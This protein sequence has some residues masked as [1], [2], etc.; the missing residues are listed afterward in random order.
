MSNESRAEAS[1]L[2]TTHYLPTY[3]LCRS[4][5]L[6]FVVLL[7]TSLPFSARAD[8]SIADR[9]TA[10]DREYAQGLEELADWC[11]KQKL[12]DQAAATR[13]WIKPQLPL[14]L[15]LAAPDESFA[16]T[17]P[18][19][20]PAGEWAVRFRKLRQAQGKS[21][22]ELAVAAAEQREFTLA[23][24]LVHATLREDPGQEAARRLLG[25]KQHEG[26]WLTQYEFNKAK[27]N[28][29]W[30]PQFG[31]IGRKQVARYEAGERFYKGRWISA[32][33]DARLHAEIDR[34][35][36]I[37]TE[38][39][40]VRTNHS[41][42]EGVVLAARLEEFYDVWRQLFVR[43][44]FTDEQLARSFRD[45]TPLVHRSRLHQ[46]TFFRDR[47]EYRAALAG[48]SPSIG[49][50]TGYYLPSARTAYFFAGPER[51]DANLCH[52]ATHQLFYEPK[53]VPEAA[54]DANFWVVEG[55]ACLMESYRRGNRLA[56]LGGADALRLINARN[57]LLRDD[58]YVGLAELCGLGMKAL[59]ERDDLKAI[60]SE[61]AGMTYFLLFADEGCYRQ[62]LVDYLSAVYTNRDRPATLSQ[63]TGASYDQLDEQYQRFIRNLP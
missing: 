49:I 10:L 45:S 59:Q 52:E 13:D 61:A 32:A 58:F 36:E 29:V 54:N 40:Q 9:Q 27:G 14:T 38:H 56:L 23:Y 48:E 53:L 50:T 4:A 26:K 51:E 21:L 18:R 39:F 41:L 43:F 57:R 33:D 63:L 24:Q 34:G 22:Y 16:D 19:E 6:L 5:R 2:L 3:S 12:L 60:Y 37:A 28:Q 35:W 30:H 25:Y 62:A 15:V 20:G 31:W 46:V 17:Q 11:E 1:R 8:E 42:E 44:L 55:I 7:T 47:D